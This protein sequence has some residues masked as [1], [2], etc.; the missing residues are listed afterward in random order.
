[1][2]SEGGG[3]S[4]PIVDDMRRCTSVDG[5]ALDGELLKRLISPSGK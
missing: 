4:K 1:M 2:G 5:L 3:G